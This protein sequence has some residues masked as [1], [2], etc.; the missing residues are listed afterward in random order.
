MSNASQFGLLAAGCLRWIFDSPVG[1]WLRNRCAPWKFP[2]RRGGDGLDD[3]R[4][5]LPRTIATDLPM[6][7]WTYKHLGV[8]DYIRHSH[9]L[10]RDVDVYNCWP[11][12][13]AVTDGFRN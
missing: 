1:A 6:Y 7:A 13:F 2:S 10:A 5:T 4:I 11:S 12:L 8:V 9:E 3:R